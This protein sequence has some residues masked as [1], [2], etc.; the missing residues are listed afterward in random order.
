MTKVQKA[1]QQDAC[2]KLRKLIQ[3]GDK[4][5]TI[6]DHVSKSGMTRHVRVKL[7]SKDGTT[8]DPNY[9]VA[10]AL[11]MRQAKRGD[12]IVA[13]GCGMD[14]G[15]SLVYNLGYALFPA[16]FTCTGLKTDKHGFKDYLH[17]CPSNDHSNRKGD[18]SPH[19]HKDGGYALR[20]EWL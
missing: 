2:E 13:Q 10:Q 12:G 5:F 1:A 15:Y 7:I 9:L 20:H 18:Y 17:S 8:H 4:V 14:M 11:D 6:L 3:P 16:G 19:T